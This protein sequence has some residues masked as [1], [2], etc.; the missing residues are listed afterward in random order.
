MMSRKDFKAVAEIIRKYNILRH[1]QMDLYEMSIEL[2]SY[3][4][5]ANPTFDKGRFLKAAGWYQE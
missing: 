4:K 3:F 5:K 2:C 1:D